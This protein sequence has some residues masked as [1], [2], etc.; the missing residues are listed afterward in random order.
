MNSLENGNSNIKRLYRST[1]NKK[2]F[3]I[4]AGF[5]DY[6]DLDPTL[7]RILWLLFTIFGGGLFLVIYILLYFIIPTKEMEKK[8]PTFDLKSFKEKRIKRSVDER[9]ITGICGGTAKYF[10]VDPFIV[11]I[12]TV[13]LDV[14]TGFIPII[15]LY[16]LL[17]WIIPLDTEELSNQ[18]TET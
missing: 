16:I 17:I 9:M 18:T 8:S 15:I 3:G 5:A 12:I 11:R 4:C 1:K 14:L 2:I 10:L 13:I 7:L 6:F